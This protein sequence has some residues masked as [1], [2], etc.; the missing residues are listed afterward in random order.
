[1][2]PVGFYWECLHTV[3]RALLPCLH[4]VAAATEAV[5]ACAD[6]VAMR[7]LTVH[8]P[9]SVFSLIPQARTAHLTP[10]RLLH[11]QNVLLTMWHVT[12]NRCTVLNPASLHP[13]QSDGD[14]HD[15]SVVVDLLC[16]PRPDLQ[17]VT[18]PNGD[19]IC[20]V[21]GRAKR[22]SSGD[23]VASYAVCTP[24]SIEEAG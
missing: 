17:D 18:I 8:V 7:P 19:L 12:L 15:C 6:I 2:R 20:F 23:P 24:H 13:T 21:D 5:L 3:A 11:R 14:A 1:M 10:A 9:H 4:S 22:S 16:K